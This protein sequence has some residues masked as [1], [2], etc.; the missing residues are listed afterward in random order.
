MSGRLPAVWTDHAA[1]AGAGGVGGATVTYDSGPNG[2]DIPDGPASV[3]IELSGSGAAVAA[4]RIAF[5][6]D[7]GALSI[8][9]TDGVAISPPHD[10]S[11]GDFV[12]AFLTAD[13]PHQI[14]FRSVYVTTGA[15]QVTVSIYDGNGDP[16][17]T[18]TADIS[19]VDAL[20]ETVDSYDPA[21]LWTPRD[22]AVGNLANGDTVAE[23]VSSA[24]APALQAVL[25]STGNMQ[26]E[27]DPSPLTPPCL[28]NRIVSD[29]RGAS[30][31]AALT[32]Y[33]AQSKVRSGFIVFQVPDGNSASWDT[34]VS[35]EGKIGTPD[36]T[37]D[38]IQIWSTS[39]LQMGVN[40]NNGGGEAR[41]E[42]AS[43]TTRL[44]F[45]WRATEDSTVLTYGADASGSWI[46]TD[47]WA[48]SWRGQ[49]GMCLFRPNTSGADNLKLYAVGSFEH[50]IGAAALEAIRDAVFS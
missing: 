28:A 49:N 32:D 8:T 17:D 47:S 27:A 39:S 5:S 35:F 40:L 21:G 18:I 10:C 43:R 36:P 14:T 50:D 11:T 15:K 30:D 46:T 42:F 2:L 33:I 37:T 20:I 34:W 29:V 24:G 41:I 22:Q 19:E 13:S 4:Y 45:A 12:G 9:H 44:F 7:T 23:D 6:G 38:D 16:V 26:I 3:T 1:F 48:A 25:S 31:Y